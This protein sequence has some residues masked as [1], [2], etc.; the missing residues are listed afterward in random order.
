MHVSWAS[1]GGKDDEYSYDAYGTNN[2][3]SGIFSGIKKALFNC[4]GE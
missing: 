2:I 4:I 3:N 1:F